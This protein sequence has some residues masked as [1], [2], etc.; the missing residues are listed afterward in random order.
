MEAKL[1]MAFISAFLSGI[2]CGLGI[3]TLADW[4]PGCG[5]K[6]A[7][8]FALAA[9]NLFFVFFYGLQIAEVLK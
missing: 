8:A 1:V 2:L 4:G 7:Q 3:F 6:A 5:K 9:L